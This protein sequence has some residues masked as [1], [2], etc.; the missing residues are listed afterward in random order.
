M[1]FNWY[2]EKT[3]SQLMVSTTLTQLVFLKIVSYV[4][5]FLIFGDVG[6]CWFYFIGLLSLLQLEPV[7]EKSRWKKSPK[8]WGF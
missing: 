5:A 8:L 1:N 6:S 2:F 3:R 4:W 7:F